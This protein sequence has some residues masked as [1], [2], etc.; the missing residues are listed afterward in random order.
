[1]KSY[2]FGVNRNLKYIPI[3]NNII[4]NRFLNNFIQVGIPRLSHDLPMLL[5]IQQAIHLPTVRIQWWEA[6]G[7]TAPSTPTCYISYD[8][9]I[10]DFPHSYTLGY[11]VIRPIAPK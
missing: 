6:K 9:P 4:H 10:A 7:A 1:M 8:I 5:T 11:A 3:I 2:L